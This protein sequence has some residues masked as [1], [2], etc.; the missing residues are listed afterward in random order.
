MAN[1]VAS[2]GAKL[3]GWLFHNSEHTCAIVCSWR[4]LLHVFRS[5][6]VGISCAG[7]PTPIGLRSYMHT[8]SQAARP[9]PPPPGRATPR[10]PSYGPTSIP[11]PP[12]A[13][14][15]PLQL[16]QA[17]HCCQGRCHLPSRGGYAHYTGADE[18]AAF[19]AVPRMPA[20]G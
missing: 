11:P 15:D 20:S 8:C 12:V 6:A 17:V 9:A 14:A 1:W 10:L 2:L 16:V 13:S 7:L 3:P 4:C 19:S 5:G 18:G